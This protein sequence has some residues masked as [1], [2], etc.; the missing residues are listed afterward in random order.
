L[1][2]PPRRIRRSARPAACLA[3]AAALSAPVPAAAAAPEGAWQRCQQAT[4]VVETLRPDLPEH[5]MA[6]M[7]RVES[8]RAHPQNAAAFAWPWTIRAQGRGRYFPTKAAAVAEVKRLRRNGVRNIDVGC[9]QV[10]LHYHGHAFETVA[11]AIDPVHN[12]AYAAE[13]L[14]K[15]RRSTHTW[16][17]AIGYYHSRTPAHYRDYQA[18]VQE[19]WRRERRTAETA[20]ADQIARAD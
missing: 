15:L 6:A 5:L 13:F 3:A 8:G 19:A 7:A 9:M 17:R 4:A 12:V 18:R 2:T 10:N 20:D 11:Q 16:M 14:R 1:A